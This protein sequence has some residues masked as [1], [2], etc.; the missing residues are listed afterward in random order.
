MSAVGGIVPTIDLREHWKGV[1]DQGA[2][3]SC[4]ACAASDAHMHAHQLSDP[5]SADGLFYRGVQ[6]MPM[7]DPKHGL[8]FQ[9]AKG[10]LAHDGQC[11]EIE[12]PYPAAT[13]SP[14]LVPAG[15]GTL[16][17]GNL[18]YKA[19]ASSEIVLKLQAGAPVVIGLMINE[20]FRD[21][22]APHYVARDEGADLG[23]HAVLGVG[24][25]KSA[26][27]TQL[28]LVR[29]S[30]G[31]QWAFGGHAWIDTGYIDAHLIGYAGIGALSNGSGK[32][33]Y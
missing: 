20:G 2:R 28:V 1:R 3:G 6:R 7:K 19:H 25:G 30:W 15:V 21:A 16:W 14:W 5:L 29:N 31:F 24:L 12:W 32:R 17:Y 4:L 27:G 26:E 9:A 11:R 10:A 18:S 23:G 22:A 33:T 8:T 13:P